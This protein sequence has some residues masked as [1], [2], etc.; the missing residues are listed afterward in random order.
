MVWGIVSHTGQVDKKI[1]W[2]NG[3][4]GHVTSEKYV[5][6][7]KDH[8]IINI[9]KKAGQNSIFQQDNARAHSAKFT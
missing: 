9:I 7:L 6:M 3:G 8:D 5:K 2:L 1:I 4:G